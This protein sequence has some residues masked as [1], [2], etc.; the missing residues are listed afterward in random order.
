MKNH[1]GNNHHKDEIKENRKRDK[2]NNNQAKDLNYRPTQLGVSRVRT[3]ST[4]E[5]EPSQKK[6]H[7][8]R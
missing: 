5:F 1:N 6:E 2:Q 3:K 8:S 4:S 7:F